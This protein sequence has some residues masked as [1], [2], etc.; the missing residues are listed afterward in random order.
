MVTTLSNIILYYILISY[1]LNF[2]E[3]WA[4]SGAA[5]ATLSSR[6]LFF[7]YL[8]VLTKKNFGVK[9]KFISTLKPLFSSL[10][11]LAILLLISFKI[12]DMTLIL[13]IF[14]ILVGF[15]VYVLAMILLRG[16]KKEDYSTIKKL[17]IQKKRI[18]CHL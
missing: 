6:F 1:L 15:L 7:G 8:L 18:N 3:L 11:M 13:G 9:I 16:F 2:S 17:F 14:L 12:T 4:I 5:V 10:I